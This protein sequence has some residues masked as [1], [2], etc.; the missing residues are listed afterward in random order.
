VPE[1][2]EVE[3]YRSAADALVGRT[4]AGVGV[5]DPLLLRGLPAEALIDALVDRT[6]VGTR[7]HGKVLLVDLDVGGPLALRFGMTGR[8]VVDG[9]APIAEL[10]YSS[11]RD[12]PRWDRLVIDLHGGGSLRLSDPRRLGSIML[13]PDLSG[14]G[15]DATSI[16][17]DELAAAV[18]GEAALKARLLDQHRVAGI[19][20]LICDETLWR[21]HLAPARPGRSLAPDEVAALRRTLRSTVRTLARRGGSHTGDLQAERHPAGVCPRCGAPLARGIVGTRTTYWCPEEQV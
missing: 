19:G 20:N 21:A 11:G 16:T 8:L 5:V 1:L 7:R 6:V 4:M 13:D 17:T 9:A 15:P 14:L 18:A 10:L 12:D 2:I 3:L